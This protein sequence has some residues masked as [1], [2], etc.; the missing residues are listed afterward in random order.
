MKSITTRGCLS[1]NT[2]KYI[3]EYGAPSAILSDNASIFA[4]R[5]W[6]EPLE[7]QMAWTC[8]NGKFSFLHLSMRI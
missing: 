1:K 2:R 3:P 8:L 5:R 7:E 6:R 4:S